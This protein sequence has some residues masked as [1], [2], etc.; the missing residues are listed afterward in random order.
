MATLN[1]KLNGKTETCTLYST[2]AEAGDNP[3]S[4]KVGENLAYA[5]MTTDLTDSEITSLRVKMNGAT[6]AVLKEARPKQ[7]TCILTIGHSTSYNPQASNYGYSNA[8]PSSTYSMGDIEPKTFLGDAFV[9]IEA[10]EDNTGDAFFQVGVGGNPKKNQS[11]NWYDFDNA[12]N[13]YIVEIP[14]FN[15]TIKAGKGYT[16]NVT[17]WE[18]TSINTA[19]PSKDEEKRM[20]NLFKSNVGKSVKVILTVIS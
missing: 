16:D 7:I 11:G 13:A 12:N 20:V 2:K 1:I 5:A 15:F 6:Y 3:L 4:V 17:F 19:R 9:C 14:Q 8:P 18:I 10:S